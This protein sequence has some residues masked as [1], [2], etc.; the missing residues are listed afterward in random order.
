MQLLVAC[1][2]QP[3]AP[4]Q[5]KEAQ[6]LNDLT[7]YY[8]QE[9]KERKS[10]LEEIESEDKR[11]TTLIESEK[12]QNEKEEVQ[13]KTNQLD[14]QIKE[15]LAAKNEEKET[16]IAKKQTP[17]KKI[18]TLEGLNSA[19]IRP[20]DGYLI[21]EFS[22]DHKAISVATKL[23]NPV[24][25]V[26]D[27]QVIYSG[28]DNKFG[29]LIIIKLKNTDYFVALAYLDDI[30]VTKGSL[31]KKGE[32]IGHAGQTGSAKEPQ[33]Y[34]AIKKGKEPINPLQYINYSSFN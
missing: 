29:N 5:Y 17:V 33:L 15:I 13:D 12:V 22:N 10:L 27:G 20:V 16:P 9:D 18:K 30:T 19:L 14:L 32:V 6:A 4:I 26:Y 1:S 23:R 21:K 2:T 28:H 8:S 25:S 34:V 11:Q 24:K 7:Q 3:P 31:V